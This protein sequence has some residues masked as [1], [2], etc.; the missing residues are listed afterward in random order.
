VLHEVTER[1]AA[2]LA[3]L[4]PQL[5]G[6]EILLVEDLGAGGARITARTRTVSAAC[7]LCGQ[8]SAAGH[9]RYPRW[10]RDLPCGGRPVEVLVSVRRFRCANPACPAATFAEQVPGLTAWYQRRTAGLR[11]LLEAVALA[12]A[13]RAGAR[14]EPV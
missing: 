7:R 8:A 3:V 1:E 4:F 13:G 2:L 6:L 11:A 5:A 10:L 12:L 9:D 14:L